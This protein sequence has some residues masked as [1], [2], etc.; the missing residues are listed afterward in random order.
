MTPLEHLAWAE[1]LPPCLDTVDLPVLLEDAVDQAG[2]LDTVTLARC[3]LE[4]KA[5]WLERKRVLDQEWTTMLGTLPS[6][7]Q[8]V[9]GPK[10]NLLLLQEMLLA[11]GSPDESLIAC[12]LAGFPVVGPP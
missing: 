2:K 5:Y 4:A 12:L 6:H 10:K 7:V 9:L 3:R 11:S 1:S 8:S